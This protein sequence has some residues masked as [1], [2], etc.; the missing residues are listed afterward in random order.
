M[1][2]YS[3]RRR[4]LHKLN[5]CPLSPI[6]FIYLFVFVGERGGGPEG[7]VITIGWRHIIN[8]QPSIAVTIGYLI[9]FLG[10]FY[11][12]YKT[13]FLVAHLINFI[14]LPLF[15]DMQVCDCQLTFW[16]KNAAL[17]SCID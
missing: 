7:F 9:C 14:F 11:P 16:L 1:N 8:N 15:L 4:S 10:I 2:W 5:G 13:R 3:R 6:L 17:L 12:L